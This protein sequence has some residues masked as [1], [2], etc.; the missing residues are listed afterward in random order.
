MRG[1]YQVNLAQSL[2]S[3]QADTPFRAMAIAD[4]LAEQAELRGDTLALR[5]LLATGELGRVWTYAK[6]QQDCQRLGRALAS[7]HRRGT[8]I[9]IYAH[10]IPEWVLMELAAGLAG[11]TLVTVNPALAARE[12]RYVLEQSRSSAIYYVPEVRGTPLG[13]VVEAACAGLPAI[14]H[15]ILLTDHGGLF[16]GEER[17]ELR[18]ADPDDIVQIQYTSGTTGFPKGALLHHKGLIQNGRDVM[19]RWG[20]GAGDQLLAIMPLFHTAG[21]ALTVLGGFASGATLTLPPG[22]DPALVVAAIE[23]ERLAFGLGVPTMIV[24]M[25]EEAEKSGRDVSSIRRLTSGGSMVSPELVARA[26]RTFG[27]AI[28]IIYGQTEASPVIT[29]AWP[30]DADADLSGTIGQPLPHMDVAILGTADGAVCAVGEQGEICVRGYNVMA[31]YNDNPEATA[32]TID[33]DGW[34]H[35]GDLGRM[36]ARGYLTIT[37]R[38]K[39][40]IIRG[41]ENLYPAEIENAML[42]HPAIA[43]AAV[44]GIPDEKWGELVA[45]FM[46]PAGAAGRPS[47]E[48]LKAFV[49]ERLS[50]QKTPAFWVWVEAWPLTG[51]GKIQKFALREALQ[52]G[53][54]EVLTAEPAKPVIASA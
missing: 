25:I 1:M 2:F 53:D 14:R 30:D 27:T 24:A 50:P 4:L 33:P 18:E 22:F 23:R 32:A 34:L 5:E 54:H 16:D 43:E 17:G 52:R 31:G 42:E 51:S 9:A 36:D 37:G 8:R 10:N 3:A 20:V 35:T 40:M 45:C 44:V 21:C 49:R 26:R 48:A 28:Q 13:P 7:R 29:M 39:E 38:V 6:L 15:R 41:G 47:P 11:L 12:V 19:A 46:R